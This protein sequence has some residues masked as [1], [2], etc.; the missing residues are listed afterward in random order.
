MDV[1]EREPATAPEPGG[2]SPR[3][4]RIAARLLELLA[5]VPLG[6]MLIEVAH[7]PRLQFIDYWYTLL[8]FT[9]PDGSTDPLRLLNL[10]NEHAVLLPS[11]AYWLD[12]HLFA[13]DN[14]VLGVLVV[15][16]AGLT[17]LGMRAALPDS[18]PPLL[19][20]GLVVG[21]SGL[22]FSLHGLWNFARAMSGI[23]WLTAN[24]LVVLALLLAAR[25]RWWPAW[26]TG[27]AASLSYG[28]G[29]GVWPALALVALIRREPRWRWLLPLGVCA[30][31]AVLWLV[32]RPSAPPGPVPAGDVG[33]IG[34]NFLILVGHVW[35]AGDGGVA[36][37]AGA[38]VLGL[39]AC[40]ATT[41]IARDPQVGYWWALAC[42]GVIGCGM[43]AAARV[44]TG[45]EF[46]LQS[47][48][49]SLSVLMSAPL[50]VLLALW[51]YRSY[52]R[53]APRIAVAAVL[54]GVLAFLLGSP[55]AV[56]ERGEPR[57]TQALQAIAIR[58]GFGDMFSRLPDSG[59]LNPP[60][61][62]LQHY[63][64]TDDFTVGCG[65]PELG[66]RLELGG[67]QRL[68]A[69]SGTKRPKQV[70]GEIEV[71]EQ[72]EYGAYVRGWAFGPDDPIRCALLVDG[73]GKVTG[74][75][76]VGLT[77]QDVLMR[78]FGITPDVGVE[79]VGP[80]DP[81]TRVVVVQQSGTQWW[82]PAR[83]PRDAQA[84]SAAPWN[85]GEPD[86]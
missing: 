62:A 30:V 37:F 22:V 49:T 84:G 10:S 76:V 2:R 23:A 74:A 60:L 35:T 50:L 82:T 15:L 80:V 59:W 47:R 73:T 21:F 25:G 31:I 3:G 1:S 27:L 7:A 67:M 56:A 72:A 36:A 8:R 68:A 57:T 77:R 63:P 13:G 78:F 41:R 28:T 12:A 39:Y 44:D 33:S 26:L 83:A 42:H 53:H 34:Y 61:K 43:I 45:A 9:E 6:A 24:L 70:T 5:L 32:N 54:A 64:F 20:A 69:P 85:N 75:G 79:L 86:G 71:V 46:G 18:L 48:Y 81:K 14:R 11:L 17:V 65:G 66:S 16:V 58:G 52:R 19:R 29:F 4:E 40:M 38:V 55:T 51:A